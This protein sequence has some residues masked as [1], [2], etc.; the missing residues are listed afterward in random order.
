MKKHLLLF[1]FVI[2]G[3]TLFGQPV[4]KVYAFEQDVLP[5]TVP[6][7][8]D[9]NGNPIKRPANKE[10][11]LI[12]LSYKK[13]CIV[14]P[15]QVF[16]KG[17]AYNVEAVT[18]QKTPVESID[19]NIPGQPKKTILVDVTSNKVVQTQLSEMP[20]EAKPTSA[21]KK[22]VK[23]NEV[24]IVYLWKKKKYYLKV[25]KFKKLAPIANQ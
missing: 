5:G 20:V 22:W 12:F 6:V 9:E 3:I 16:I 24:V 7:G 21:I 18:V 14:T 4:I 23:E 11:Y 17:A 10:N 2:T 1:A 25:K 13:N 19:R 8:T 15:S